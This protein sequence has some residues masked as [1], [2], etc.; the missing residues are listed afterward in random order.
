MAA[1]RPRQVFRQLDTPGS[2]A[3]SVECRAAG[4]NRAVQR[5]ERRNLRMGTVPCCGVASPSDAKLAR[6]VGTERCRVGDS[7][8][9][10][11]LS[12][13]GSEFAIRRPDEIGAGD[14]GGGN[15]SHEMAE[16]ASRPVIDAF[17]QQQPVNRERRL[18]LQ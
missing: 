1:A 10:I 8:A 18:H 13:A 3:K 14:A 4:K 17:Q 5:S 9:E 2:I 11:V 15:A 16:A 12:E 6:E 7:K